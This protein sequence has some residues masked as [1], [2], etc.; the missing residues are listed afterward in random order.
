[1]GPA[2]LLAAQEFCDARGLRYGVRVGSGVER[3]AVQQK[4][5]D[6]VVGQRL[7]RRQRTGSDTLGRG[8]FR[9]PPFHRLNIAPHLPGIPLPARIHGIQI[10][11]ATEVGDVDPGADAGP[12]VDAGRDSG[13][14]V[15]DQAE[16]PPRPLSKATP[17]REDPGEEGPKPPHRMSVVVGSGSTASFEDQQS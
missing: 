6:E 8:Q 4:G 17:L 7:V 16:S 10:V 2:L 15:D 13:L 9:P 1:V 11:D 5:D 3:D 14:D 12:D